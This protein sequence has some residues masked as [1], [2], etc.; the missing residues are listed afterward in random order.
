MAF[1]VR[2]SIRQSLVASYVSGPLRINSSIQPTSFG[3]VVA[4]GSTAY[5]SFL[6]FDQTFQQF[7]YY[8]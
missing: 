2:F 6:L 3:R 5:G 8:S 4:W 1:L 7:E